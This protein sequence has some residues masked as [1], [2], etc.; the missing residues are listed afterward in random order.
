MI[1]LNMLDTASP[2]EEEQFFAI[3]ER[4]LA[5][6]DGEEAARH[7]RE[8]RAIF[9]S[10]PRYPGRAVR[11]HPDGRRELMRLEIDSGQLV[12]ERAI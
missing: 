10:D 8:G 12:V 7:L 1:D 5:N 9:I 3:F 4:M 11:E 6:D 2:A